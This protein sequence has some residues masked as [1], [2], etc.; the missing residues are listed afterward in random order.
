MRIAAGPIG[1]R[2]G[3]DGPEPRSL[4][5]YPEE[6]GHLDTWEPTRR[7][8][9][10]G[11]RALERQSRSVT[12][13]SRGARAR[14]ADMRGCECGTRPRARHPE[15]EAPRLWGRAAGGCEISQ[16]AELSSADSDADRPLWY[17]MPFRSYW[18]S[19][20]LATAAQAVEHEGPAGIP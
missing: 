4:M 14:F 7:E 9:V 6:T 5:Y 12:I 8:N 18:G 10:Q 3:I 15:P 17:K 2:I 13:V 1:L 19:R 11:A 16:K 20:V